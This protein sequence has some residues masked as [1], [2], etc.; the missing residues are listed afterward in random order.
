MPQKCKDCPNAEKVIA[1]SYFQQED[2]AQSRKSIIALI[3]KIPQRCGNQLYF[4][5]SYTGNGT[6][7]R[8]HLLLR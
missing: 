7:K 1:I 8:S 4:G 2:Y 3:A 6:G 5:R